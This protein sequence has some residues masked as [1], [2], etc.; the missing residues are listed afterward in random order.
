MAN[1]GDGRVFFFDGTSFK[2]VGAVELG[3]DADNVRYDATRKRI[4][5]GYG[6]GAL[7]VID[8]QSR[9]VTSRIALGAH[10]ESFQI[11]AGNARAFVNVPDA[12]AL[13]VVDLKQAAVT[14]SYS[15]GLVAANFPMALD[16]VNHRLF[17]GC[18]LPSRLLVFDTGSGAKIATLQLHD[19]CDDLFFD[20]KR[21]QIYASCGE[22]YLDIF[23]QRDAD[24]YELKRSEETH[25]G[26]RTSFFDGNRIFLA[27]PRQ[28]EQQAELDIYKF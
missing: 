27:V 6:S 9:E 28:G 19:D 16:G 20:P 21:R 13:D 17:V 23:S 26:A 14:G 7:A 15:L 10:P 12:H 22:G 25:Q 3:D 8:P 4:M 1:G 24:H 18:R 2:P 11:E 5:V